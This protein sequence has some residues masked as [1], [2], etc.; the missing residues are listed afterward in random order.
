ME[1]LVQE[2]PNITTQFLAVWGAILSTFL[3]GIEIIKFYNEGVRIKVTVRSGFKAIP[4]N[5]VYGDKK[6]ILISTSNAGKRITTITHAWLMTG[7]KTSLLCG[8]CFTHGPRKIGEGDY[9]QFMMLEE[10]MLKDHRMRPRDYIACVSD[11]AG[12]IFYS[13]ALPIRWFKRARM[14]LFTEIKF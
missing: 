12:R 9:A 1:N 2:T 11:A 3:A 7:G 4:V 10:D 13:H 6:Y 5:T 14:K 8:E